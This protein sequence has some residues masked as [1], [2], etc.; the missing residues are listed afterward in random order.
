MNIHK[1]YKFRLYPTDKQATLI[2]KTIGCCRF[3]FNQAL[4]KQD[5]KNAYWYIV[6]EMVQNGQLTENR[7]KSEFFNASN[8]QKEL[9]SMK[10]EIKWLNEVDRA[11][12]QSTLQDLGKHFIINQKESPGLKTKRTTFNPIRPNATITTA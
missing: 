6:H 1:A 3:V 11:A 12:L 8:A 5:K 2:H 4:A 9:I 7:W 10:K